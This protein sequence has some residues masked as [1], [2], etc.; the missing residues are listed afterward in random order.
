MKYLTPSKPSYL[1]HKLHQLVIQH[2]SP[3]SLTDD[4]DAL[5]AYLKQVQDERQLM[6]REL[7]DATHS[8]DNR[9]DKRIM[10]RQHQ[11]ALTRL[12]DNIHYYISVHKSTSWRRPLQDPDIR[13]N[14]YLDVEENLQDVMIGLEQ[15]FSE[16]MEIDKPLPFSYAA[17]ARKQLG[18]RLKEV[19]WLASTPGLDHALVELIFRPVKEFIHNADE[20]VTFRTLFYYRDL[21]SQL[22][23]LT[24][25]DLVPVERFNWQVHYILLHM[26]FNTLEYYLYCTERI[27]TKLKSYDKLSDRIICLKWFIKEAKGIPLKAGGI[28]LDVT[29]KPI[30]VQL[31]NWLEDERQYLQELYA[32]SKEARILTNL[33]LPQLTLLVRLFIDEGI[34]ANTSTERVLRFVASVLTANQA[35]PATGDN[36]EARYHHPA[37]ATIQSCKAT[38][39][40][41]ASRLHEYE[42]SLHSYAG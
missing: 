30:S 1:M 25:L 10:V 16:F 37:L 7:L 41:L 39:A 6:T 5:A 17:L 31:L 3:R 29:Q 33:T 38:I 20:R 22:V 42:I 35:G 9:E 24:T 23:Q 34:I 28:G 26:N 12:L 36:F 14:F 13:M 4:R 2:L 8:N 40:R 11:A 21:L 15:H 27:R 32:A 18:L 19:D